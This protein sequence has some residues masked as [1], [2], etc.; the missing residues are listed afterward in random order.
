MWQIIFTYSKV[1]AEITTSSSTFG[2]FV[3]DLLSSFLFE[4]VS[5]R[6]EPICESV[7]SLAEES[8]PWKILGEILVI[9]SELLP[10]LSAGVA[11]CE[12]EL[13]VDCCL[14]AGIVVRRPQVMIESLLEVI[15]CSWLPQADLL[16]S[17]SFPS[18]SLPL[19]PYSSA[20]RWHK[21]IRMGNI[22]VISQNDKIKQMG[23]KRQIKQAY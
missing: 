6:E 9:E 13:S 14:V 7:A 2:V 12:L 17:V 11:V 5:F 19:W 4:P 16:S 1:L 8:L 15:S 3:A 18:V 10:N 20:C 23:Q 21:L 22:Q